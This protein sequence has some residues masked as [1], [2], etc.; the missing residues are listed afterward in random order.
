MQAYPRHLYPANSGP[1]AQLSEDEKKKRL[2]TMVRIWQ[3]DTEKRVERTGYRSVLQAAGLDE[4]RYCIWLRLPE[5]E[6]SA[7]AGQV[8]TPGRSTGG[9]PAVFTSWRRDPLLRTLS[10]WKS[11]LPT[12]TVFNICV[13]ITPGGLGEGT[14][15][16]VV[17]PAEFVARYRPGWPAQQ[18]WVAW[19][20]TFD[21]LA[22]AVPFVH[23]LLNLLEK[24]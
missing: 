12:E 4:Y 2:D 22:L 15:W 17:M 23:A 6:R 7:V 10:D 11:Q 3:S 16:A 19:T 21:W 9:G 5:W 1:H 24:A 18:Q 14:K 20:R 8:L 13:R